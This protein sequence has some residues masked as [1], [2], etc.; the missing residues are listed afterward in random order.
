MAYLI[1]LP[2]FFFFAA[3]GVR[4]DLAFMCSLLGVI[5]GA[6]AR[7]QTTHPSS[8]RQAL[9]GIVIGSIGISLPVVG[10]LLLARLLA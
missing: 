2:N 8:R 10:L 6:V 7:A 1:G 4:F 5:F 9:A 3:G